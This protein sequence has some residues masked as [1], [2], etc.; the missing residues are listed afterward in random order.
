MLLVSSRIKLRRKDLTKDSTHR[1]HEDDKKIVKLV[2]ELVTGN[3]RKYSRDRCNADELACTRLLSNCRRAFWHWPPFFFTLRCPK[4]Y[5]CQ[6]HRRSTMPSSVWGDTWQQPRGCVQLTYIEG[7]ETGRERDHI[8]RWP[9]W[10]NCCS[11]S[12]IREP[13]EGKRLREFDNETSLPVSS[14]YAAG[15]ILRTAI[16]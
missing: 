13:V 15:L 6:R 11:H 9:A 3:V 8:G 4:E 5:A 14:A 10:L 7:G 1:E 16:R 2:V 12:R